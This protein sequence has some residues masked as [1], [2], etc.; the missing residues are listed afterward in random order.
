MKADDV[1][2]TRQLSSDTRT[3]KLVEKIETKLTD[4]SFYR[5]NLVKWLNR[6]HERSQSKLYRQQM[7][8]VEI[9][10]IDSGS[11]C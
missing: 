4:V 3:G 5:S 11:F 8:S 2:T 9:D 6:I 7:V 10:E 1:E